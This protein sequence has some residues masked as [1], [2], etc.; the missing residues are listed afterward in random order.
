MTDHVSKA[1]R[2]EIMSKVRGKD[3]SPELIVRK[4]LFSRGYRYRLHD[5]SLPGCPDIVF[6][7]K[8][9]VIFVHGCFW[10]CHGC[11]KGNPPKTNLSYWLPKLENNRERDRRNQSLLASMGWSVLVVWQCELSDKIVLARTLDEFCG[12]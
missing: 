10:H 7:C 5:K 8:K 3:T 12:E 2:S 6:R 1:K 9:R 4:L 11:G